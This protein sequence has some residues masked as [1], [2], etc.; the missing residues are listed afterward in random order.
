MLLGKL[1][2]D[3]AMNTKQK[4]NCG[5]I[6]LVDDTSANL[7][8][9]MNMLNTEGYKVRPAMDGKQALATVK[10]RKPDLILL[11]VNMPGIDGL[12]VCRRLKADESTRDI[13]VIFISALD[14]LSDRVKGFEVGGVDYIAKPFQREEVLV[15]VHTHIE[16]HRMKCNLE[17]LVDERTEEF[18]QANQAL[19][20]SE[21]GLKEAQRIGHLGNWNWDIVTDE[22]FWSDEIYRIFGLT[23]QKLGM[24]YDDFLEFIHPEDRELLKNAVKESLSDSKGHYNIEHRIVRPDG[25]ERIVSES[26]EVCRDETGKPISMIGTVLD[27]TERKQ[28]EDKLVQAAA[29]YESTEEGIIITD[30]K[31]RILAVNPA[32][33]KITNYS[34]AEAIGQP[35]NFRRS[36]NH[37]KAYYQSLWHALTTVGT[38]RGEIWN[39]RKNGEAYPEWMTISAIFDSEG[40]ISNYASVFSDISSIKLAEEQLAFLAHYDPLTEL[41]NRLLLN[42]RL[43]HAIERAARSEKKLALLFMDLDGFK[44]INDTFGHP[45]GDELLKQVTKRLQKYL[46]QGDILARLGGDEFVLVVENFSLI[47]ELEPVARKLLSILSEPFVLDGHELFIGASIGISLYPDDGSEADTL[48]RNADSAMYRAKEAGRN[49]HQF[50]TRELTQAVAERLALES[51]LRYAL[52]RDEFQLYYQPQVELR[53]GRIIGVEALIRWQSSQRGMVA[54]DKFIPLA[55]KSGLILSIGEWVLR[56]AC[57]Q[58]MQ[59][60]EEGYELA[61]ISV[62]VSALQIQ[63]GKLTEM[64]TQV[65]VQTGL[66]AECLDLEITESVLMSNPKEVIEL[67]EDLR[68]LGLSLAVDDFGTGYSS[69]SYLKRF[70]I[71]TLKIDQAF[72]RDI[73]DDSNDKAIARA[74]IA[75]G[76]SLQLDTLAEGVETEAQRDFLLRAG[77]EYAQGYLYSRPLPAKDFL[78]LIHSQKLLLKLT[79]T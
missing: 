70:P 69:L 60:R 47:D 24:T 71:N 56:E 6:L 36:G 31:T 33:T 21:S 14:A 63:R 55:E 67:L 78:A 19:L 53:S 37:D 58:M 59:W 52:E 26:G 5:E 61:R 8:L 2:K 9:L 25:A 35:V 15:R 76:D 49:N 50:Y 40:K 62:N 77:C 18:K 3:H 75:L 28:A 1:S 51:E 10:I 42:D 34:A 11:D 41:P 20:K 66:E 65:L 17:A 79:N 23:P 74:I 16:L 48:I 44:D 22:L 73:P 54:P 46:H 12:E 39:C 7:K 4:D 30:A 68:S 45:M 13:P 43:S 29:V 57:R 32:F 38:W 27:I 72:V 64:V